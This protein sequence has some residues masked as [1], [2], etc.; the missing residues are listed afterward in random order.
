MLRKAD[1]TI[2]GERALGETSRT[3]RYLKDDGGRGG[4]MHE[5]PCCVNITKPC[6]VLHDM[7][8]HDA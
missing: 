3:W 5:C 1:S 2:S 6:P 4:L 7:A 8:G